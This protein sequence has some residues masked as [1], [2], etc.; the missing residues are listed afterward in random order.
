MQNP[1]GSTASLNASGGN[2]SNPFEDKNKYELDNFFYSNTAEIRELLTR[3]RNSISNL[4]NLQNESLNS[5]GENE[6]NKY[7]KLIDSKTTDLKSLQNQIKSLLEKLKRECDRTDIDQIN[8]VNNLNNNFK[9]SLMN[10]KKIEDNFRINLQTQSVERYQIVNPDSTHDE[11]L[12]FIN[13]TGSQQIFENAIK[14]KTN[15]A[16]DVLYEVKERYNEMQKTE[17]LAREISELM[18]D[19]QELVVEQ[20]ILFDN[21]QENT[22]VA[23][24]DIER[25]DANVMQATEKA[26]KSRRLKWCILIC[27]IILLA[28]IAGIVAGVVTHYT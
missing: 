14:Y 5:I 6:T 18:S 10:F 28:A 9:D 27:V 13:S 1:F 25:G 16:R 24:K 3:F 8:Q 20:D 7:M 19:L 22:Q 17:L 11:A 4:I 2:N 15:E 26:K 21:I 12:E 23:Q